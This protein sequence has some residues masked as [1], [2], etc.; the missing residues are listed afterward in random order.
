MIEDWLEKFK[1]YRI[2]KDCDSILNIFAD[3][4]KF[5]G[6]GALEGYIWDKDILKTLYWEE[7]IKNQNIISFNTTV[8]SS[9]DDKHTVIC[10][11]TY[12]WAKEKTVRSATAI[13]LIELK[14]NGLCNY[15][16]QVESMPEWQ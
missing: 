6:D 10:E 16:Y 2:N 13:Y 5:Y 9:H 11:Y 15:F 1:N 14:P 12:S 3:K 7:L 4:F 8:F